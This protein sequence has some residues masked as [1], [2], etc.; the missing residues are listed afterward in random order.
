MS[1][2][3]VVGVEGPSWGG[4]RT[5]ELLSGQIA[6]PETVIQPPRADTRRYADQDPRFFL[7]PPSICMAPFLP[8]VLK[9][10]RENLL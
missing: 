9:G 5:T 7:A 1:W 8:I 2:G 3:C 6:N 10:P 4:V